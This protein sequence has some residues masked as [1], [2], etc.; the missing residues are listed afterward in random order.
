MRR[1]SLSTE[2]LPEPLGPT[3][4]VF[5]LVRVRVRVRLRVRVRVRLGLG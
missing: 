2:L 4:A 3:M 1:M 5:D